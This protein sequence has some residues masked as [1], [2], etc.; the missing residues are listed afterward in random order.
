MAGVQFLAEAINISL[1]HSIWTRSGATQLL[2]QWVPGALSPGVKGP[3]READR[4]CPDSTKD[5]IV[6]LYLHSPIHLP[7]WHGA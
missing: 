2:I 5:G 3:V 1:L 4:S 7:S 6:E